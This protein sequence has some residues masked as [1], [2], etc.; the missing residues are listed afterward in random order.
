ML[1]I[2]EK[3]HQGFGKGTKKSDQYFATTK[4]RELFG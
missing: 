4:T 3:G 1:T 2:H